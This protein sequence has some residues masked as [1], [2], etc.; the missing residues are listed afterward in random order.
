MCVCA[1]VRA[2]MHVY[3]GTNGGHKRMSD[4]ME[5]E[6]QAVMVAQCGW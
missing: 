6:L 2:C 3:T 1:R 5:M 4:P